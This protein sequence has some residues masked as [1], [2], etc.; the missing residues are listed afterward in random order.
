MPATPIDEEDLQQRAATAVVAAMPGTA[1]GPLRPL[2]GGMS[3]ITYRASLAP[4]EGPPEDVVIKVAPAGLAPTKNRDVL[5]QA[6]LQRALTATGVPVPR[7]LASHPGQP[8]E[9]PPFFIMSFELGDCVEPS[10]LKG[11]DRL[12]PQEVRERMLDAARILG[13]LHALNPESVGLAEGEPRV[14]L[15]EELD[16]WVQSLAACDEDLRVGDDVRDRLLATIPEPGRTAV[17]HGDF[18]LGN[19]L[20]TQDRVVSVIDWEIWAIGDPRVDL[21]WFLMS[22]NPDERLNRVPADGTPETDA[23]IDAY[24]TARGERV[25]DLDWFAALV[26][27]KQLAITAL[28]IRNARRRGNTDHAEA[29]LAAVHALHASARHMLGMGD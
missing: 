11:D 14:S 28:L 3:S 24:E 20:S 23:L 13:V 12:P 17:I 22:C 19:T 26:R 25:S 7:V 9:R 6:R 5:R 10:S 4:P 18:R 1:L 8:P 29:M 27:Y 16:R 21:A 15:A 2:Q